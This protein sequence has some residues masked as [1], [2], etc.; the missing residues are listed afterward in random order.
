[1]SLYELII[2]SQGVSDRIDVQWG[3]F[4]TMHMA[5]F[6]GIVYVDRPLKPPEKWVAIFLYSGFSIINY[7][8]L[9]N[10]FSML[11]I[12]YQDIVSVAVNHADFAILDYY[13]N[14]FQSGLYRYVKPLIATVHVIMFIIV[15]VS[16]ILDT[17]KEDVDAPPDSQQSP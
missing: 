17:E 4:I 15:L 3:F 12:A 14:V 13:E 5:L 16:I 10:Q 7:I 2:I 1:M 9:S 6:G 11:L 8:M